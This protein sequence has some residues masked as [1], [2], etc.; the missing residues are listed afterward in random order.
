MEL[1][2]SRMSGVISMHP[3]AK[4]VGKSVSEVADATQ[5]EPVRA[6]ASDAA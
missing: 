1:P 4:D 6:E 2:F 3:M 5:L